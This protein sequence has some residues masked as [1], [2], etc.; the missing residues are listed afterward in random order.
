MGPHMLREQLG[1][2]RHRSS[3]LASIAW[4]HVESTR[5]EFPN[6][7]ISFATLGF[8]S[9]A[10][11][12]ASALAPATRAFPP[13]HKVVAGT[14]VPHVSASGSVQRNKFPAAIDQADL[15]DNPDLLVGGPACGWKRFQSVPRTLSGF[16]CCEVHGQILG[17]CF[18]IFIDTK[19]LDHHVSYCKHKAKR[20][21][22]AEERTRTSTPCR[23]LHPECSASANS[24]TS[25]SANSPARLG[26]QASTGGDYLF[27]HPGR[28]LSRK[29]QRASGLRGDGSPLK[30][31]Q[32][33]HR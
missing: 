30:H 15:L 27:C 3:D 9:L 24:A 29:E 23:A 22:G 33:R 17:V 21:I 8:Q 14:A 13:F 18:L 12:V 6:Q 19:R 10:W 4:D 5:D 11:C 25:A 32:G 31:Y 16:R 1:G 7:L 2:I 20:T 26:E 28:T